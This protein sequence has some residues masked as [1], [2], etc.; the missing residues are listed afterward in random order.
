[1]YEC[2]NCCCVIVQKNPSHSQKTPGFTKNLSC[3]ILSCYCH[4]RPLLPVVSHIFSC[5]VVWLHSSSRVIV[6]YCWYIVV[7]SPGLYVALLWL[8]TYNKCFSSPDKVYDSPINCCSVVFWIRGTHQ[9]G[10]LCPWAFYL[11][12][13]S[14][15]SSSMFHLIFVVVVKSLV[16]SHHIHIKHSCVI[17]CCNNCIPIMFFIYWLLCSWLLCLSHMKQSLPSLY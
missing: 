14:E 12:W 16:A 5:F 7:T 3:V 4:G 2:S 11:A 13:L 8:L 15:T 6:N 17:V 1:M 9:W 10:D